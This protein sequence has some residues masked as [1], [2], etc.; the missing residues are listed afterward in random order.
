MFSQQLVQLALKIAKCQL[1]CFSCVLS[2]TVSRN[3]LCFKI[4]KLLMQSLYIIFSLPFCNKYC[5]LLNDQFVLKHFKTDTSCSITKEERFSFIHNSQYVLPPTNAIW[6]LTWKFQINVS[7]PST[8][9]YYSMLGT[10]TVTRKPQV[11]QVQFSLWICI[12]QIIRKYSV[13]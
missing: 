11:P 12:Q 2:A 1:T 3:G 8:C 5:I 10:S 13:M 9:T 4:A 6:N 7:L